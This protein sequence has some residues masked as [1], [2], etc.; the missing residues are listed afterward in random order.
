MVSI[1]GGALEIVTENGSYDFSFPSAEKLS[2]ALLI[3]ALQ[4]TGKVED[5]DDPRFNPARFDIPHSPLE[6]AGCR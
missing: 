2:E 4:G 5:L 6:S 1:D 3:L